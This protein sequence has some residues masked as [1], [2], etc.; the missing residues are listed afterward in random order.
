MDEPDELLTTHEVAALLK[1]P[2]ST[3]RYW[4]SQGTGPTGFRVGRRT[5]YARA[6]V[7]RW[8]QAL[9]RSDARAGGDAA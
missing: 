1:T 2:A 4:R 7:E 6:D 3:V 8:L 5:L 9:R